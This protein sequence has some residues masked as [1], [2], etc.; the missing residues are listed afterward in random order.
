M[1]RRPAEIALGL[2]AA[3]P[4]VERITPGPFPEFV[5]YRIDR[6]DA[7]LLRSRAEAL[8]EGACDAANG[9]SLDRRADIARARRSMHKRQ[10]IEA[11]E[12]FAV[13]QRPAHRLALHHAD[14]LAFCG[15]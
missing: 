13:H 5:C 9:K 6:V 11:S 4:L 8:C 2:D 3:E 10:R 12:V 1:F 15:I 7:R 14:C